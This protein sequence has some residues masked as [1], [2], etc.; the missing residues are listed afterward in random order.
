MKSLL[1]F[2]LVLVASRADVSAASITQ[3]SQEE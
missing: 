1:T 2:A 3:Q